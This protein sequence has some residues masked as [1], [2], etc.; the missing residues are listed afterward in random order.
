MTD[1]RDSLAREIDEE[2]RREQ[3]LKLWERYGT[4]MIAVAA[5]LIIG[6]GGFKY[7]EHRRTA[8]AEMAG[9]RFTAAARE[10]LQNRTAEA[11][12]ALEEIRS[13]APAGYAALARLRLAA[14]DREAGRRTEALAAYEAIAKEKGLDP[15][16]SDYARLQAAG[17]RL[18]TADWTEM[19]NRL[20]DLAA[21]GNP[22]RFSARELLSLAAQKAGKAE[23]ARTQLQHLLG[24]RGTPPGIGERARMMLAMLTEAELT[25][26]AAS[27]EP[28]ARDGDGKAAPLAP[29]PPPA[30][31]PAQTTK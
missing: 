23:E 15:L 24:D 2:L 19:Q 29:A 1:Q 13:S 21:D 28:K 22:W 3:L 25:A 5:L 12:K 14:A 9:A 31:A 16:L 30:P 7:F 4:Y 6:I 8:A 10:A 17:L 20:N 26:G 11:Q 27:P 18:D